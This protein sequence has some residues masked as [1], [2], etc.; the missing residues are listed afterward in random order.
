LPLLK[1]LYLLLEN[2]VIQRSKQQRL[3]ATEKARQEAEER[4][5][6]QLEL[7][8]RIAGGLQSSVSFQRMKELYGEKAEAIQKQWTKQHLINFFDASTATGRT[9][10]YR[11]G[12]AAIELNRALRANCPYPTL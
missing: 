1:Q 6:A 11:E 7:K 5:E 12:E 9:I 8:R 2:P 10:G 4:T 3:I